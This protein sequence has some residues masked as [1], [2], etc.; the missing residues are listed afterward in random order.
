M[1]QNDNQI[2][3]AA[4]RVANVYAKLANERFG[5]H[6]TIPVRFEYDIELRS[7]AY[8]KYAAFADDHNNYIGV[9][10]TLFRLNVH[11]FL[12]EIIPH[13]IAHLVQHAKFNVKGVHTLPHGMHWKEIMRMLGKKPTEHHEFDFGPSVSVY[14]A[15]IAAIKAA[16]KAAAKAAK[17]AEKAAAKAAEVDEYDDY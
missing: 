14:K 16:E 17:A 5:C 3:A 6:L 1:M 2:R 11:E 15:H 9:N 10:S 13:E 8:S 4:Q 7:L 12:N